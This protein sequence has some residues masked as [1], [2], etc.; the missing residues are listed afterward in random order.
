MIARRRWVRREERQRRRR[1]VYAIGLV[2]SITVAAV[3]LS[4]SQVFA[5]TEIEVAG[6]RTVD[7]ATIVRASGLRVGQNTMGLDLA[8]AADAVRA[9]PQVRDARV[10][11]TGALG[12]VIVVSERMPAIEV[13]SGGRSW[14]L[15]RNGAPIDTRRGRRLPVLVVDEPIMPRALPPT[16]EPGARRGVLRVWRG[17]SGRARALAGPFATVDGVVAFTIGETDVVLGSFDQIER[18]LRVLDVVMRRVRREGSRLGS[19]DLRSP[20]HPAATIA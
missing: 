14:L 8:A 15:D 11:R 9:L 16:V 12:I 6:A 1:I 17:L 7:P 18:K 5:L 20:A 10:Q 13:R 4:G 3:V 19:L 2:A